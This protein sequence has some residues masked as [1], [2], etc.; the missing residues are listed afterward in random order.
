MINSNFFLKLSFK[1]DVVAFKY[2]S[3]T[4]FN[5]NDE[6]EFY[7]NT[8]PNSVMAI[9]VRKVPTGTI[10]KN[11]IAENQINEDLFNTFNILCRNNQPIKDNHQ[12]NQLNQF[13]QYNLLE[14][15]SN[16][17]HNTL[18]SLNSFNNINSNLSNLSNSLTNNISNNI[19]NSLGN[20]SLTNSLGNHSLGN[21]LSNLNSLTNI[22]SLNDQFTDFTTEDKDPVCSQ[23]FN[24]SA[25]EKLD[26]QSNHVNH[27]NENFLSNSYLDFIQQQSSDLLNNKSSIVDS[28]KPWERNQQNNNGLRSRGF[29]VALKESFGFIE[30]EDHQFEIFFHF[31]YVNNY[32]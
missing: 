5:L 11:I 20:H 23:M 17:L 26:Q 18:S 12:S 1:G 7:L 9:D 30:S 32:L 25:L 19:S 16:L 4:I 31:R 3:N 21:N 29:I 6:V 10:I 15:Q 2:D 22:N 13:K 24:L 8:S 27:Q 14:Q 28:Q